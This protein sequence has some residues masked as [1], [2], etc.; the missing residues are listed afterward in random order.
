MDRVLG[1]G[2]GSGAEPARH[3]EQRDYRVGRAKNPHCILPLARGASTP[4]SCTWPAELTL[5]MLLFA[6]VWVFELAFP[7]TIM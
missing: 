6:L 7:R 5:K 3:M 1:V 4:A 2:A